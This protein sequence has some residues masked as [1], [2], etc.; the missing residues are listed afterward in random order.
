MTQILTSSPSSDLEDSC[1]YA[2]NSSSQSTL[3]GNSKSNAGASVSIGTGT[4]IGTF[5]NSGWTTINTTPLT[6]GIGGWYDT[7][8]YD[9]YASPNLEVDTLASKLGFCKAVEGLCRYAFLVDDAGSEIVKLWDTA[10]ES[11]S[12]EEFFVL[13]AIHGCLDVN[14]TIAISEISLR[15]LL[16]K[17]FY[18]ISGVQ[19]MSKHFFEII[20]GTSYLDEWIC[21]K[22]FIAHW[23]NRY[24]NLK[25]AEAKALVEY[26]MA[27][28]LKKS[29]S[30]S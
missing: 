6:Q 5:A 26:M 8:V 15:R 7:K 14:T 28:I 27:I 12:V 23:M 13:G 25:D 17:P 30:E 4:G 9:D 3:A 22:E 2:I 29:A 20:Q 24:Q 1:Q 18:T 19:G 11:S 10:S 21:S 16:G